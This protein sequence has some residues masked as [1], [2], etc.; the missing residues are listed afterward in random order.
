MLFQIAVGKKK[1]NFTYTANLCRE[2]FQSRKRFHRQRSFKSTGLD[3]MNSVGL[4][5]ADE[6]EIKF[7]EAVV[8]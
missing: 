8:K 4:W 2:I 1:N 6:L 5:L 7:K 3:Y